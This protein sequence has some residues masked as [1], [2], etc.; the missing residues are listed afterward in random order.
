MWA[1]FVARK[2]PNGTRFDATYILASR[3]SQKQP[4]CW[5]VDEVQL[6]Y[7]LLDEYMALYITPKE[8]DPLRLYRGKRG[9]RDWPVPANPFIWKS[10]IQIF[11]DCKVPVW[12]DTILLKCLFSVFLRATSLHLNNWA[13]LPVLRH[14][15][16]LLLGGKLPL[17][18]RQLCRFQ[19]RHYRQSNQLTR[20]VFSGSFEQYT[21]FPDISETLWIM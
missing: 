12:R 5:F 10:F 18:A 6:R 7:Q 9:P 3:V 2:S 15:H 1:S 14:K 20:T 17:C 16:C 8:K 19:Q 13:Y 21:P 11:P 4:Q